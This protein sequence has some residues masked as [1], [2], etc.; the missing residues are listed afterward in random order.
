MLKK[1]VTEEQEQWF[2]DRRAAY[3][4]A[5]L[6]S[7]IGTYVK[8]AIT[9]F[10]A[11]WPLPELQEVIVGDTPE[12]IAKRAA[13]NEIYQMRKNQIRSK[14]HNDHHKGAKMTAT[15]SASRNK[16]VPT[17]KKKKL[18]FNLKPVHRIRSVQIYSH[19]YY[20]TRVR[21]YVI[22]ALATASKLGWGAKLNLS[23]QI[24]A[25]RA[26]D[27]APVL[28]QRFLQEVAEQTGWWFSVIAGGPLPTDNGNIHTRSFHIGKTAQGRDFLDEYAAFSVDPDDPNGQCRTFEE[29]ISAPYGRFLKSLFSSEVHAQQALN[30]AQLDFLNETATMDTPMASPSPTSPSPIAPVSVSPTVPQVTSSI[31]PVTSPTALPP[32]SQGVPWVPPP[33]DP[34]GSN[35]LNLALMLFNGL[36]DDLDFFLVGLQQGP[37]EDPHVPPLPPLPPMYDDSNILAGV[38]EDSPFPP[39]P[40]WPPVDDDSNAQQGAPKDSHLLPLPPLPPLPPVHDDSN[41]MAVRGAKWAPEQAEEDDND[42]G[43][44][45]VR[46]SKHAR[47]PHTRCEV[48]AMGWLPPAVGYLSDVTLGLQ[49][50]NLLV[51]WQDLKERL[52]V[53]GC[54]PG[55]VASPV[56]AVFTTNSLLGP[57]G[58]TII[59]TF[60]IIALARKPSLQ[61]LPT[62]TSKLFK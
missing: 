17:K 30:Q 2:C 29:S 48:I 11:E 3:N 20:K 61:R 53:Q 42:E 34:F 50:Q 16:D 4:L 45:E 9:D 24:T 62:P 60:S 26:I 40:P 8:S 38:P 36:A 58:R 18:L 51:S 1:W 15:K 22:K 33:M 43:I 5:Q 27:Q 44:P 46:A 47:K 7:H 14:F 52:Q 41:T 23:N 35:S 37:P 56:F 39:L 21:P 49:W 54:S 55:K 25:E 57:Y 59:K 28:L 19:R 6:E 31:A 13:Q 32:P 10:L 12:A